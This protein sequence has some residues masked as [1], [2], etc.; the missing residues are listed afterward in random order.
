MKNKLF[1][2]G[3]LA[4]ALA[5]GFVVMGCG[6][7]LEDG[8]SVTT[9]ESKAPGVGNVKAVL[10][11]GGVVL[12]WDAAENAS[13]YSFYYQPEGKTT[14]IP[15][16]NIDNSWSTTYNASGAENPLPDTDVDTW[17]ALIPIAK[18]AQI[19][20]AVGGVKIHYGIRAYSIDSRQS[21]IVWSEDL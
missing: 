17:S 10:T 9:T 19:K 4:M 2:A 11:T 13:S 14:P 18:V 16:T 15:L 5:F 3:M 12:T 21:D 7:P 1:L 8:G 6:N 20:T